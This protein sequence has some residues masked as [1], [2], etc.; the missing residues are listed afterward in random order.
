[1]RLP[2]RLDWYKNYWALK[3]M[4]QLSTRHWGYLSLRCPAIHN[5]S[6]SKSINQFLFI[7][8]RIRVLVV[9][10]LIQ[11]PLSLHPSVIFFQRLLAL[12]FIFVTTG[13]GDFRARPQRSH[14]VVM[15]RTDSRQ[16]ATMRRGRTQ[17]TSKGYMCVCVEESE[18]GKGRRRR[19]PS[20]KC[21]RRSCT[22]DVSSLA[23]LA[24]PIALRKKQ[25]EARMFYPILRRLLQCSCRLESIKF[26]I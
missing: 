16:S 14:R 3:R 9:R 5:S 18:W 8:S 24:E 23:I 15:A 2:E 13:G 22:H 20:D 12:S 6:I 17:R 11:F 26:L 10:G 4:I 25:R 19:R 7:S 1:M 21:A